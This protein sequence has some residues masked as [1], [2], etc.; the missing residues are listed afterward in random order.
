[1]SSV[2]DGVPDILSDAFVIDKKGVVRTQ[3]LSVFFEHDSPIDV[4][5]EGTALLGFTGDAG[6]RL[7]RSRIITRRLNGTVVEGDASFRLPLPV[8]SSLEDAT[9][10]AGSSLMSIMTIMVGFTVLQW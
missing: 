6:T 8:A 10:A 3:M 2:V 4:I 7:L 1:V 5:A 9:S